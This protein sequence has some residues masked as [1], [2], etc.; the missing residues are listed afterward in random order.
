MLSCKLFRMYPFAQFPDWLWIC[1]LPIILTY[2]LGG[3]ASIS[4]ES[5]LTYLKL[6]QS[7]GYAMLPF[8]CWLDS[9]FTNLPVLRCKQALICCN[10]F[11]A[12]KGTWTKNHLNP[13]V[14]GQFYT[15]LFTKP[16]PN[17]PNCLGIFSMLIEVAGT[18]FLP[19]TAFRYSLFL[20]TIPRV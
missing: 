3:K 7:R 9:C 17:T 13:S 20:L 1:L 14:S 12:R 2:F 11:I 8:F 10:L 6:E 15:L 4:S 16:M 18:E 19:Q 5:S